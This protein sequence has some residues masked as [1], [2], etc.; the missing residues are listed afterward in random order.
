MPYVND[1]LD[2]DD[3]EDDQ[4]DHFDD[5][6]HVDDHC[7]LATYDDDKDD[8]LIECVNAS[9][10]WSESNRRPALEGSSVGR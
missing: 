2:N 6:N 5:H 10:A 8:N 3:H 7:F 1:H 4:S 9:C